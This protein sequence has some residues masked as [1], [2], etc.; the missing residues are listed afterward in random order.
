LYQHIS[1]KLLTSSFRREDNAKQESSR[2]QSFLL[3]LFSDLE[4]RG[5][6][7]S[8]KRR[9]TFSGLHGVIF[10]KME[11]YVTTTV[12]TSSLAQ[13]MI[14][15]WTPL[16]RSLPQRMQSSFCLTLILIETYW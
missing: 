14:T 10:Q 13:L 1:K 8:P 4:N 2:E 6:T 15:L 5:T 11:I 16:L 9:S 12:R 7:S 3:C